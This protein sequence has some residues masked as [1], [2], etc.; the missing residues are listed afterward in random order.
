MSAS[1]NV[2]LKWKNNQSIPCCISGCDCSGGSPL[3]T[4]KKKTK[5]LLQ[6]SFN[7]ITVNEGQILPNDAFMLMS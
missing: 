6:D 3:S 5:L 4:S 7:Y 1:V 2:F